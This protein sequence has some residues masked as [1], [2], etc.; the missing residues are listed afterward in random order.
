MSVKHTKVSLLTALTL[1]ASV[2]VLSSNA[3]AA[4]CLSGAAKASDASLEAFKAD[5]SSV[6]AD[7]ASSGLPLAN[8]I[9][10]LAASD[11]DTL[12][13]ILDLANQGSSEQK[14]AIGAGLARAAAA[15]TDQEPEYAAQI[16]VQV[17]GMGDAQVLAAFQT[18]SSDVATAALGGD[19]QTITPAGGEGG[20]TG[21]PVNGSGTASTGS[22][23]GSN[24]VQATGSSNASTSSPTNQTPTFSNSS[25]RSGRANVS[26]ST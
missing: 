2:V 25:S 26:P 20:G 17:A 13:Q 7:N 24:P 14:A 11:S 4:S 9:R 15:C 10:S 8:A 19:G 23:G 22:S 16:Q 5:P 21:G 12:N 3:M 6:L 1:G 18:T